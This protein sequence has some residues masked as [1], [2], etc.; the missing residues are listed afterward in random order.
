M[1]GSHNTFTYKEPRR[2]WW[3]LL[4]PLWRCQND[5]EGARA[6]RVWDIRVRRTVSGTWWLCHGRVDLGECPVC[7][8]LYQLLDGLSVPRH[9]RVRVILERGDLQARLMFERWAKECQDPRLYYAAIKR[10]W[11]LLVCREVD[12]MFGNTVEEH[13]CYYKPWDTGLS[14]WGNLRRW[15]K[16]PSTLL[17][18]IGLTARRH[19]RAHGDE[20]DNPCNLYWIDRCR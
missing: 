15:L 1:I 3:L 2:W 11:T 6:A 14:L 12:D 20:Y 19:R 9:K 13:D 16:Q 4:W 8:S 18:G 10:P 5:M 7:G 17:G